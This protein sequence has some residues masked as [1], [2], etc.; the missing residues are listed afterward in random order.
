[1]YELLD[2]KNKANEISIWPESKGGRRG[3]SGDGDPDIAKQFGKL[4]DSIN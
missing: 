4:I 2:I 3:K 1:M